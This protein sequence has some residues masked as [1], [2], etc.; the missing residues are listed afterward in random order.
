MVARG[1][2]VGGRVRAAGGG[3]FDR[4]Y[5]PPPVAFID[6]AGGVRGGLFEPFDQLRQGKLLEFRSQ[7]VVGWDIHQFITFDDG[8][9]V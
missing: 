1:A 7:R 3:N 9:D 4:P 2:W 8:A 5:D 6:A